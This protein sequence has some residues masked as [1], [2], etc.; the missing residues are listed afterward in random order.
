MNEE[1]EEQLDE[2]PDH[3]FWKP[4]EEE[5]PGEA[6]TWKLVNGDF[7]AGCG[8]RTHAENFKIT[9]CPGCGKRVEMKA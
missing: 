9:E 3:H 8:Y 5:Q 7:I 1:I 4:S 6:C 2:I